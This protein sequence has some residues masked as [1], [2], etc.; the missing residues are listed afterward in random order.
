MQIKHSLLVTLGASL[1]LAI[2]GC[3]DGQSKADKEAAQVPPGP[4]TVESVESVQPPAVAE[5]ETARAPAPGFDTSSL[6]GMPAS[7]WRSSDGGTWYATVMP[8]M[9]DS[10]M[11]ETA[12]VTVSMSLWTENG[13]SLFP[14]QGTQREI[15]LP[16][17]SD[18]F[19]GWNEGL[20]G[21]QVGEVRKLVIP[22]EETLGRNGR[23][24]VRCEDGE[25]DQQMLVIDVKLV[26]VDAVP[27][28]PAIPLAMAGY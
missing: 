2:A 13:T 22:Y 25:D 27:E 3:G 21:M 15:V 14:A 1:G 23:G 9:G 7:E 11:P 24:L 4:E 28:A 20:A 16:M 12:T 10:V 19:L 8:G 26:A 17:G 5:P 6:P 18:M